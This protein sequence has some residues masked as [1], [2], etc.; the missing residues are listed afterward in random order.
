MLGRRSVAQPL[1][2]ARQRD[3]K[4][5]AMSDCATFAVPPSLCR[6]EVNVLRIAI[7]GLGQVGKTTLFQILTRAHRA[8]VAPSKTETHVG[9]VAVP[10]ARLDR[11]SAMYQPKKTVHASIEYLDAP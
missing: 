4:R 11:L 10:D 2:A 7:V 5:T 8:N 9:V 1:L 3:L 6:F